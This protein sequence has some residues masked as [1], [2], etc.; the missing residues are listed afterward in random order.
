MTTTTVRAGRGSA[1]GVPEDA[2]D[3]DEAA[4]GSEVP[5]DEA[6]A[7]PEDAVP[8]PEPDEVHPASARAATTTPDR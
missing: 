3:E 1:A 4:P 5:G 8:A 2:G 7:D 6:G